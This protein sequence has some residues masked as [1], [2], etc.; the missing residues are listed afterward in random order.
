MLFYIDP[1]AGDPRFSLIDQIKDDE[2]N[3]DRKRTRVF[4]DH[5]ERQVILFQETFCCGHNRDS[6]VSFYIDVAKQVFP[7]YAEKIDAL[8]K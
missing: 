8:S 3:R 7:A 4:F 1:Y 2:N 6:S 5:E